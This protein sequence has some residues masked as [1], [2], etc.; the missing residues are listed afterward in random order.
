[1]TTRPRLVAA[2]LEIEPFLREIAGLPDG[3]FFGT[4]ATNG[5]VF[6][7]P[8]QAKLLLEALDH[9]LNKERVADE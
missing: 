2:V 5:V 7:T 9:E 4:A 6:V 3:S 1:M 8:E